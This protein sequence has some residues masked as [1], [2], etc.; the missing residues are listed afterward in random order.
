[1]NSESGSP[2]E[3]FA[4]R[5]MHPAQEQTGFIQVCVGELGLR[6]VESMN[7]VLKYIFTCSYQD[8]PIKEDR[9][10]VKCFASISRNDATNG[11]V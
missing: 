10:K 1:M 3:V 4:P 8:S 5:E 2:A 6:M 7:V 11:I 9:D